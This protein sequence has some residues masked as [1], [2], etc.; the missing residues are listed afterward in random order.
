MLMTGVKAMQTNTLAVVKPKPVG[1]MI[2]VLKVGKLTFTYKFPP[3]SEQIKKLTGCWVKELGNTGDWANSD[4]IIL[5]TVSPVRIIDG[6]IAP[7]FF[8]RGRD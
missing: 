4:G 6:A 2:W 7:C 1:G 3:R 5:A 8:G